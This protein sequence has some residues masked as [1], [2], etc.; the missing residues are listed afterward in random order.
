MK[1]I[2]VDDEKMALE[3][4][5]YDTQDRD[6]VSDV[7]FFTNP[8]EALEYVKTHRVDA[9]FLDITMP[10]MDGIELAGYLKAAQPDLEIVYV[11]GY[12]D[13]AHQAYKVGG[14]AYL[15]KPYLDEEL[16]QTFTLLKKLVGKVSESQPVEEAVMKGVFIRTFVNF[17]LLID[18]LPVVFKNAKAKELLALLVD[19]RGS[20]LA[21][22]QIFHKLWEEK[23]YDATTSTYVR[24]TL[25]ALKEQL[26][27]LGILDILISHRNAHSINPGTFVCDYYETMKG[28]EVYLH[29]Y[30]GYYMQQYYWAEESIAI[31]ESKIK[32]MRKSHY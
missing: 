29:E 26:E 5:R 28:S 15:T 17:D 4:F 27:E 32:S 2:Y 25:R 11:T 14:R 13:Y 8:K 3:N 30:N 21:G 31:V 10:E 18:G 12:S 7:Q 9:A 16:E 6:D 23:E 19:Y 20:S 22:N 1:L 24:R